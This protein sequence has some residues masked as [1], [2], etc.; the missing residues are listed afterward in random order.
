MAT[1][2]HAAGGTFT[3]VD[4]TS[5]VQDAHPGVEKYELLKRI[6]QQACILF[7]MMALRFRGTAATFKTGAQRR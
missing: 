2:A 1:Q 4:R 3:S 7:T 5:E 6:T